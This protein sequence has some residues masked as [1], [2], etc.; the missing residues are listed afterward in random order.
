MG[1]GGHPPAQIVGT[2]SIV[3]GAER[4]ARMND[5]PLETG[6]L[7]LYIAELE[8]KLR[9]ARDFIIAESNLASRAGQYERMRAF[10]ERLSTATTTEEGPHVRPS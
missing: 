7:A 5:G 9:V 2:P 1:E 8:A 4:E 6:P 3:A 10:A